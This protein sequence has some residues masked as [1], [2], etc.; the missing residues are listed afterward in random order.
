MVQIHL[1]G[2]LAFYSPQ[3]QSRFSISIDEPVELTAI[4]QNLG[5]PSAEV[6]LVVVNGELLDLASAKIRPDDSIE[7][8]PPMGGG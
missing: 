3:K 5:I 2:H 8:F 1:G 4:L 6:V 7:L